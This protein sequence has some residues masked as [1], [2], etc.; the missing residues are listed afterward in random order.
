MSLVRNIYFFFSSYANEHER[1][2]GQFFGTLTEHNN[3]AQTR[4]RLKS[5]L[6]R[7]IAALNLWTEYAY[8]GYR[9]L[10]KS[11]RRELYANLDLIAADFERF[12]QAHPG[13]SLLAHHT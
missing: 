11:K 10:K 7:D 1:S 8:K 12:R 5:L 13:S 3:Q 4:A 2:V 9:Y 6:Q